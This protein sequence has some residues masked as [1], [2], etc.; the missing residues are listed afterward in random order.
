M[1]QTVKRLLALLLTALMLVSLAAC[2]TDKPTEPSK[3]EETTLAPTE[4]PTDKPTDKPDDETTAEPTEPEGVQFPLAEE[5]TLT[6]MVANMDGR[7]IPAELEKMEFWQEIYEATNV[8][9][10]IIPLPKDETLNA[11]NAMFQAN[12]E[13]DMILLTT[14][15]KQDT[16]FCNMI[17]AGLF[18]DITEYVDDEKLMP[19]LHAR[20]LDQIPQA[21]G[22]ITSPEGGIYCLP[23][24]N[25]TAYSKLE[26]PMYIN[27]TWLDKAGFKLEDIKT[28][29]DLEKVLTYFAENDMNGNG[30]DDEI[31]YALCQANNN[32]HVEA[33]SSLYGIATKGNT[34]DN[35]LYVEDGKVKFAYTSENYK[36]A[37][38]KLRDWYNKGLIW[39]EAFTASDSDFYALIKT[40][41]IGLCSRVSWP[42][43]GD[44]WVALLPVEVEGYKPSFYV[45]PGIIA[46]NKV[47]A[48]TRSCEEPEIALAWLD[49]FYSYEYSVRSYYGDEED[50]RYDY[51]DGK[52]NVKS[53]SNEENAKLIEE[54]PTLFNLFQIYQCWTLE[55]YTD[56]I[57]M[58]D[59]NRIKQDT[60][61]AYQKADAL[62]KE[63]WPRPLMTADVASRMSELRTDIFNLVAVKRAAWIE[64]SADIDA[65]WDQYIAD[66]E[67]MNIDEFISLAQEAYDVY[68]EGMKQ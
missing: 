62:N 4:K 18:L 53:L 2:Q 26:S 31:P 5:V 10:E 56:R 63:I 7:D 1:K 15:V 68:L 59:S 30:I 22:L 32:A 13:G 48:L 33:F 40:N 12:K 6:F 42:T 29:D 34:S 28:I 58:S 45:N 20:V 60:Y 23:S 16:D 50:G 47:V 11:V 64:G 49:L 46:T 25:A 27:K 17:D 35:G 57:V 43:G 9:I 3:Q 37:V 41:N 51:V 24:L 39:K 14:S 61:E 54:Q 55:D 36:D 38:K 67:K 21:R 44:E 66:L 65:D 52:L 19:N 8:K